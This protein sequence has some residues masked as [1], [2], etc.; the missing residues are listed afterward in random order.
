MP[1][2]LYHSF[3]A[4]GLLAAAMLAHAADTDSPVGRWQTYDDRT[5]QP[6][7]MVRIYDQDGK[8]FGRVER[9]ADKKGDG[10]VCTACTD[11][12]RGQ[13]IE[14]LVIIR[15]MAKSADDPLEWTGGDVLD[16]E[17]GKIYR[18]RMKLEDHGATLQARGFIGISLIGRT[19]TWKRIP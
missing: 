17:N 12:R 14:G 6:R 8:L 18:F 3:V 10:A 16:P 11:D 4:A 19:Q 2:R 13:P 9:A 7:G 15:N 1:A 5:N